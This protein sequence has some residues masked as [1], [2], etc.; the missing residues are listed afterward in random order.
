LFLTE[1]RLQ[2]HNRASTMELSHVKH[3]LHPHLSNHEPKG[4]KIGNTMMSANHELFHFAELQNSS[5]ENNKCPLG[6]PTCMQIRSCESANGGGAVAPELKLRRPRPHARTN[7]PTHAW[8]I[9][10]T[11]FQ[12]KAPAFDHHQVNL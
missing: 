8:R 4:G 5:R 7:P 11:A 9:L 10:S 1:S 12:I 6:T 2:L 3:T